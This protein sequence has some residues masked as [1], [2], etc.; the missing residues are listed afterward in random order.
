MEIFMMA[1]G[2]NVL[3]AFDQLPLPMGPRE[4]EWPWPARRHPQD[5]LER[6]CGRPINRAGTRPC[7]AFVRGRSLSPS[8]R[9]QTPTSG[10]GGPMDLPGHRDR[11]GQPSVEPWRSMLQNRSRHGHRA[12]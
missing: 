5:W 9:D 8:L 4:A 1:L 12:E 3:M 11:R 2:P 6:C 7:S 10:R